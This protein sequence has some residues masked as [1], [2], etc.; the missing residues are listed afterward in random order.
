MRQ[1]GSLD[2]PRAGLGVNEP[3]HAAGTHTASRIASLLKYHRTLITTRWA[4]T[5][6]LQPGAQPRRQVN[7]RVFAFELLFRAPTSPVFP[8]RKSGT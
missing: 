6:R 5:W 7:E 1:S 8:L 2:V 3:H 4:Q